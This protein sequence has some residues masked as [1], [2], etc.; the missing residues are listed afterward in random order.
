M[1]VLAV[2]QIPARTNCAENLTPTGHVALE[3]ARLPSGLVTK[4]S[5]PPLSVPFFTDPGTG[6]RYPRL[7]APPPRGDRG[8][9]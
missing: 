8:V 4:R 2:F 3:R 6:S 1:S 7:A 9:V 5:T